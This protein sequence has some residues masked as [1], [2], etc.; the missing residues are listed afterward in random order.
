MLESLLGVP[1]PTTRQCAGIVTGLPPRAPPRAGAGPSGTKV[2][3]VIVAFLSFRPL[4]LSHEDC[5]E[6]RAGRKPSNNT[7]L[8]TITRRMRFA[9]ISQDWFEMN[10]FSTR[11]CD[12]PRFRASLS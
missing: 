5:A 2:A 11:Q 12:E 7:A 6:T 1:T 10:F 8:A 4:R 3:S 9:T